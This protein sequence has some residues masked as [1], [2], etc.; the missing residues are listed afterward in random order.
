MKKTEN[1]MERVE[2]QQIPNI[3]ETCEEIENEIKTSNGDITG[4]GF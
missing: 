1:K 2:N 4:E 3:D